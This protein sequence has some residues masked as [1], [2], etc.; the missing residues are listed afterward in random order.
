MKIDTLVK[1]IED[2]LQNGSTLVTD[3]MCSKYGYL[4]AELLKSRLSGPR[5]ARK[6]TLRMSNVGKPCERQVWYSVNTPEDGEKLRPEAHMKFLFGDAI[7]LLLLFL[8]EAAGHTVEG[9]QDE[10]EIEGIKGHRDAVIDGVVIDVKSAS[11]YSFKKFKEGGLED[12]D[13]FG[14]VDQ[15]QSYLFAGQND[16]KVTDKTRAGFLVVDKTLGHICLDMHEKKNVPYEKIFRHKKN[17]VAADS[18]P[19]KGFESVPEG[20]SGNR[21]L[22]TNCSYCDFRRKCWPDTKTYLYS[23]GPKH[24]VEVVREPGVPLLE[25]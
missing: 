16:D 25:G 23:N 9:T 14:Y 2:T 7:E 21:A 19:A 4:F 17:M 6:G 13:P 8:S 5:E 12:N 15:I 22:C 11:T 1:D 18:P 20:K 24:L 10:Q 3:E